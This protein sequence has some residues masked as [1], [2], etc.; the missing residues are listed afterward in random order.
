MTKI[1]E[2]ELNMVTGG[3]MDETA[4]DSQALYYVGLMKE[5]FSFWEL[6]FHW[7]KDS[8]KVDKAWARAGITSV[9]RPASYNSYYYNGKK[10]SRMD[11]L[12]MIGF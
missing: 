8:A 5:Q 1:T 3:Y 11:A 10:I 7:C 6:L 9:T 2:N 12:K 4:D